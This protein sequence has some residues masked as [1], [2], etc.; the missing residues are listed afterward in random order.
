MKKPIA[1]DLFC[2][3]G[4]MS[5]GILQAGFHIVF[6]SD[7]SP[8]ASLTYQNRHEQLG[9]QN[10][11]NT[12]FHTMDIS[13]LTGDFIKE[14]INKLT[15]F[16]E[17]GISLEKVDAIFGGP[18]CQGFS[19][20]GL[21][22]K[23]D[24]RNLLF[25]E[26]LRVISEIEPNYVVMENVVGILDAKLD[27]F[28][29]VDGEIYPED[30]YVTKILEKEFKKLGYKIKNYN[31]QK[32]EPIDFKKLVLN[33]S[34][35]GVPQK[36]ERVIIIAY[37]EN[38][39]EPENID[40]YKSERVVTIEEALADLIHDDSIKAKALQKLTK[41]GKIQYIRDSHLGRTRNILTNHVVNFENEELL[42]TELSKHL[43]YIVE[44]FS[45]FREGESA[46]NVRERMGKE[47]FGK[48]ENLK[49]LIHYSYPSIQKIYNYENIEQYELD[50]E[51]LL[52]MDI[53]K[54]EDLLSAM[55]S[56]KNIR[57]RLDRKEPSRTVVTLPDDYISPFEPRSFSVREMAR[58]QS[59]DD[60][61]IFLGKRTT[62]GDRRKFE[63][64]QYTQVGNAVPPLLARAV[65]KSIMDVQED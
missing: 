26:Y 55:L 4:G 61:F 56:K 19:R 52:S 7:K 41:E 64:P 18:P 65:A 35:F 6:S 33:A 17:E 28:I 43:P 12:S 9:L 40:N 50:L 3:A 31:K 54:K 36:R 59:F 53:E 5:E 20:A 24:P 51:N 48:L 58:L 47:G 63:V 15:Y 29:S 23:D 37:K 38:M 21:R 57:M 49:N 62:G 34:H 8:E 14:E 2:G 30:Y 39:R 46:K 27:E 25:R 60:S 44:R 32:D 42:N 45:L 16:K 10:D 11:Y 13:D 22:K 1:I